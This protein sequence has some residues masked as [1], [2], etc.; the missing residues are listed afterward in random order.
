MRDDILHSRAGARQLQWWTSMRLKLMQPIL[1]LCLMPLAGAAAAADCRHPYPANPLGAKIAAAALHEYA[2]F[3][4]HRINADGH[5]WK[6][7]S[8]ESESALLRDPDS[9][10]PDPRRPGRY[11]WRRVWE[12][13]Q[14]LATHVPGAAQDRALLA[15][16]GLLDD[17]SAAGATRE[18]RLRE[19]LP[20]AA[21]EESGAAQA[22]RQAAVRAAISDSAWSAAFI[23]YVM[24]RAGL[25]AGQFRYAAAHWQYVQRAFDAPDGYAYAAC[26]PRSTMPAVGDLL[27]YARGAAPLKDFAAW[28]DA[29]ALPGFSAAAHCEVVT[30]VDAGASKIE[31]VGGNVLQ[32]VARRKLKLNQARLLS[33]SHD[34]DRRRPA[35]DREC[36]MDSSC[37]APNLNLQYWSILLKL[38]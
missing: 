34:P 31:T 32:S 36:A 25:D 16:P 8:T 7:G 21:D 28:R 24:D 35:R 26:D 14:T 11:A 33:Q 2:E 6:F 27:C 17:S 13:W 23:S 30:D 9:G 5:L 15:T 38:R 4:G 3:N 10:A 19:L 1:L 37:A 22:L 18:Y 29:A 20:A 12:Y